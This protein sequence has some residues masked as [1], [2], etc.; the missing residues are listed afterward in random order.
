[1]Q[2]ELDNNIITVEIIRKNN[3]NIYFRFKD[4]L[5][6][7]V[8]CNKFVSKNKIIELVNAN[9]KSI[10]KMYEHAKK[11]NEVKNDFY[12]LGDKYEIV[13]QNDVKKI[14]F[15]NNKIFTKDDKMLNDFL[16]GECQK[17]FLK[18]VNDLSH[19]FNDLPDFKVKI[20]SMKT[21]WGVCNKSNNTITLNS[22]LIKKEI[23]LLDYVIIHELCH[24]KHPNHSKAFWNEVSIYYPYYKLARKKLREV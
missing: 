10:L 1:M 19:L 21:R 20:R 22:E 3:K 15:D 9:K 13:Y 23:T 18:R 5:K 17:I 11:L 16:K 7:Y 8:S 24:F 14:Y 4:D 12:Y 6:L 2:I